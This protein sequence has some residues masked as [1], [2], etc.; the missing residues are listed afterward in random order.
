MKIKLSILKQL[1]R[2][3]IK[4]ATAGE[5]AKKKGLI[6]LGRGIY[7]KEGKPM[8]KSDNGKLVP[9]KGKNIK[10]S[11]SQAP[12][13]K[14]VNIFDKP[15]LAEPAK[16]ADIEK[17]KEVFED[18]L[19][20][21][22]QKPLGYLPIDTMEETIPGSTKRMIQFAKENN[23]S[24]HKVNSGYGT[25]GALFLYDK[26]TLDSFLKKYETI[27]KNDNIP[28]NSED[29]VKYVDTTEVPE[30]SKS[31]KIVGKAFGD[32]RFK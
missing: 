20:V 22:S 26:N 2:E 15:K 8:F 5:E 14:E 17:H 19:N 25:M 18:L 28:T 32:S 16:I 29:F 24:I 27:L 3:S 1:I 11:G 10:T 31:F 23:L 4:E 30:N 7:G 21:G 6:H 12:A 13:K 9:L